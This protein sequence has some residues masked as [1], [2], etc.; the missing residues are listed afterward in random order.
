T[1]PQGTG[2]T[3]VS[4]L[5]AYKFL[6]ANPRAK[7]LVITPTKELRQQYV[8]M[9]AWMG[10]LSPRL[11]V[12]EFKEPLS[13]VRKQVSRMAD[14]ADLIVTTPEMFTNRLDWLTAK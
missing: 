3:F 11:S 9:A 10:G 2:K 13:G 12:L 8:R 6:S 4:Q 1:L 14:A 5:I 7:I